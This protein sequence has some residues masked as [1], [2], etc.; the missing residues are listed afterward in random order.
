MSGWPGGVCSSAESLTTIDLEEVTRKA[1][2]MAKPPVRVWKAGNSLTRGEGAVNLPT[3][4]N[5]DPRE[6]EKFDDAA[7]G[8]WD[9]E[10][11]FP[12]LCTISILPGSGLSPSAVTWIKPG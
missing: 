5:F 1:G 11:P 7:S 12:S 6:Q 4:M 10:G 9:P 8:W 3:E 2:S